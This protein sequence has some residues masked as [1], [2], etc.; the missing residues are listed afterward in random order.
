MREYILKFIEELKYEKNYSDL[1]VNG[2]LKDLDLFLEYINENNIKSFKDI[3]YK[4]I[5][6]LFIWFKI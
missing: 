4:I 3:E 1:T 5:H 2:Y 6:K